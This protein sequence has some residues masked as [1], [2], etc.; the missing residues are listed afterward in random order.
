M[1]CIIKI[2]VTTINDAEDLD[3]I[4]PMYH[5]TEY[6]SNYSK[7]SGSL[8][9]YSKDEATYFDANIAND[10]NFKN[11]KYWTK[12]IGSTTAVNGILE[13]ETIAVPLKY[14]SNFGNHSKCH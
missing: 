5:L 10:D 13:N 14:L 3:L 6:S 1:K 7:T 2:D 11:F 9:L 4:M 8:W 12:L